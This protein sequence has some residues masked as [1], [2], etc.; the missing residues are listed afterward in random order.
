M[1]RSEL[2]QRLAESH[3]HLFQRDLEIIVTRI[4]DEIAAALSRGDRVDC[5]ASARSRSSSVA[6]APA[7]IP[8]PASA[9]RLAR[10][11]FRSSRPASHCTIG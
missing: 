3:P 10:G 4:F 1:T 6:P 2:V 7:A 5:V 8:A 9:S 11:A